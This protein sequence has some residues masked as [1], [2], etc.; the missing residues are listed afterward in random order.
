MFSLLDNMKSLAR[1]AAVLVKHDCT[2]SSD[3]GLD[4]V[5]YQFILFDF[6]IYYILFGASPPLVASLDG[7]ECIEARNSSQKED[8]GAHCGLWKILSLVN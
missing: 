2:G 8:Q 4:R 1:L 7:T 6:E 3:G 5:D